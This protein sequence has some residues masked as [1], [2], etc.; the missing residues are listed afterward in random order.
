MELTIRKYVQ[1][2]IYNW[3][4]LPSHVT[5]TKNV[6]QF[7]SRFDNH[8]KISGYGMS[9]SVSVKYSQRSGTGAK[10]EGVWCALRFFLYLLA[11]G[12]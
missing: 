5:G 10:R 11:A 9:L 7:K 12:S 3:R 8:L 2:V 4:T 6:N 1:R